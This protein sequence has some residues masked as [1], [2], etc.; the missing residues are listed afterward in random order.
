MAQS[1]RQARLSPWPSFPMPRAAS[2]APTAKPLIVRLRNWVGDVVLGVPA[3][4][5]LQDHGHRLHL[6]GRPWAQ[7]LLKG[8]GWVVEPVAS[9]WRDKVMQLRRLRRRCCEEDPFFDHRH[10]NALTL[11]FSFSSAMEMRLA[12]LK[13]LGYRYEG[14]AALLSKSVRYPAN[15][16]ELESYWHLA[17]T[18]LPKPWD[19]RPPPASIALKIA[20]DH[21]QAAR[22]LVGING[23][24]QSYVV[25]CPFA[26]GTFSKR[27]KEWPGFPMLAEQLR[28]ERMPLLICPGPGEESSARRDFPGSVVLPGVNLGIYAALLKQA[29]LMISNDTGPG[30]ISAAVGTTT[31]SVLGPTDA[32]QWRPWGPN[33]H[34][35][36]AAINQWP[37]PDAVL[38]TALR[39]LKMARS[40]NLHASTI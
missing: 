34:I 14:R 40:I 22:K 24:G 31:L 28:R 27:S 15:L 30:H 11:P 37:A 7:E 36:Q 20:P 5:A 26:G 23:L 6:I 10:L 4:R 1:R 21:V 32:A 35:V 12:G 39:L 8:E 25:L 18:L 3:L 19:Q 17:T 13:C 38:D 33:V 2:P 29:T 16:H 9:N